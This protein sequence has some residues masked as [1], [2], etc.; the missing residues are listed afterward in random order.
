MN[1]SRLLT[2]IQLLSDGKSFE[3]NIN[4][5]DSIWILSHFS[6]LTITRKYL[7]YLVYYGDESRSKK[8]HTLRSMRKKHHNT[9]ALLEYLSN[10]PYV[11]GNLDSQFHNGWRIA[12]KT[13]LTFYTNSTEERD[14][15]IQKFI[16]IAG[17][18][19]LDIQSLKTN[20]TYKISHRGTTEVFQFDKYPEIESPDEFWTEEMKTD[21]RRRYNELERKRAKE[22]EQEEPPVPFEQTSFKAPVLREVTE[23]DLLSGNVF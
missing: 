9:T 20:F 11:I 18:P 5:D 3:M 4:L 13:F 21:W 15:L 12:K 1:S 6:H 17:L 22:R 23:D 10:K 14:E 7:Q 19:P 2:S 8:Q 16:T